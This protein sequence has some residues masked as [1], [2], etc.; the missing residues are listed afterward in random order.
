METKLSRPN[1]LSAYVRYEKSAMGEEMSS[2][3]NADVR[4]SIKIKDD[5]RLPRGLSVLVIAAFSILAWAALIGLVLAVAA[6]L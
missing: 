5:G 3:E 2:F 1:P 4:H 6:L